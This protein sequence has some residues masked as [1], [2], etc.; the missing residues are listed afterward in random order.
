MVWKTLFGCTNTFLVKSVTDGQI[1]LLVQFSA[2]MIK[3]NT[4]REASISSRH[5][6]VSICKVCSLLDFTVLLLKSISYYEQ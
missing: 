6:S 4:R 5:L 3:Q 1:L 2:G